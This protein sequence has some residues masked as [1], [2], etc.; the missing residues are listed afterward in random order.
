MVT[1]D[2]CSRKHSC[3]HLNDAGLEPSWRQYKI[4]LVVYLPVWSSLIAV[5]DGLCG[6]SVFL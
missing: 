6:C 3:V 4:D 1:A 2:V 5:L